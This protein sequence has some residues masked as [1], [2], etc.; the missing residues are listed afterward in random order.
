MA[1]AEKKSKN[2]LKKWPRT[3][4]AGGKKTC[5]HEGCKLPYR[6]KGYCFL[7]YKRWRQGKL[8]HSRYRTCSK[9]ECK[10]KVLKAGLCETHFNEASKKAAPAA[11]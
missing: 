1:D 6:A 9:A 4:K 5:S 7:H 8:P 11:A 10:K 2:K 3:A